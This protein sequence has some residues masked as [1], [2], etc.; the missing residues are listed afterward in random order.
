MTDDTLHQFTAWDP[1]RIVRRHLVDDYEEAR[2]L[3]G[4]TTQYSV[5]AWASV[6]SNIILRLSG[7]LDSAVVLGSLK[8]SPRRPVILCTHQFSDHPH[9]DERAFARLAADAADVPRVASLPRPRKFGA[10]PATW[11]FACP[12]PDIPFAVLSDAPPLK[13]CGSACRNC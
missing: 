3:I 5:D 11:L 7:G 13:F 2:R 9:D 4:R 10:L 1:R 8:R 12:P 6:F